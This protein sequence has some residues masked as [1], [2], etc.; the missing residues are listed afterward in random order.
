MFAL[1]EGVRRLLTHNLH[2]RDIGTSIWVTNRTNVQ[3]LIVEESFH[4]GL[5]SGITSEHILERSLILAATVD[6]HLPPMETKLTTRE[7]TL[8]SSKSFSNNY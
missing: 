3:N 5:V 4:K 2:F 8:K 6:G 7:G 1:M